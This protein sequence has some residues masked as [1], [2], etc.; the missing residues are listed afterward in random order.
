MEHFDFGQRHNGIKVDNV[1]LPIWCRSDPR[2]FVLI[3]R[4][5]LESDFVSRNL[6]QWI[7][8]SKSLVCRRCSS[9][10]CNVLFLHDSVFGYKQSGKQAIEALNVFH[11]ATY[12]GL[13]VS[14]IDDS[15]KRNA[16]ITMIRTFGQ[17]PKQLF[18][19]PHP[20]RLLSS[21]GSRDWTESPHVLGEVN[22]LKWG[23][24]VG[25]PTEADP[26]IVFSTPSSSFRG[27]L[28]PLQTSDIF[29]LPPDSCLHVSYNFVNR[30]SANPA[31][32]NSMAI[33]S[34]K[35]SDGM[36]RVRDR[37]GYTVTPFHCSCLDSVSLCASLSSYGLL[38]VAYLS[39]SIAVYSMP[40]PFDWSSEQ[41]EPLIPTTWLF[42]HT[43]SV[44]A[45]VLNK[46][47]R[48]SVTCDEAGTCFLW[49]LNTL[50][51]VRT[52]CKHENPVTQVCVSATLG[53]IATVSLMERDSR[54]IVCTINGQLISSLQ[55]GRQIT[56]ICY[57]ACPEGVSVN[58][59]VT[60]FSD[61]AVQMWSS[62][63]L[64]PVRVLFDPHFVS[65][66]TRSAV[67]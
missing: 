55:P 63:D 60:G 62:W 18:K 45:M 49:D 11:P 17:M 16:L 2:L 64:T 38:F 32:V 20:Q 53:D 19:H 33:I 26:V 4:Q 65:P 29:G 31:Y 66:V 1:N 39:G 59:L 50:S 67:S 10:S 23:R 44:T 13:E 7:D 57:S 48:V 54:L 6:H 37:M 36:I 56:A 58:V 27:A 52:L 41:S 8:L 5:A 9:Y 46:E 14:K 3:N 22:G 15:L 25:S 30:K 24:F 12:Y 61:G 51:Y 42:A 34:W 47:F 21:T 40:A 35:H 28:V 43:S